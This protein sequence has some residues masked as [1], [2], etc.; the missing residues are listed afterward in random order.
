[1]YLNLVEDMSLEDVYA[2]KRRI[3]S[4]LR[5]DVPE[6]TAARVGIPRARD[7][8]ICYMDGVEKNPLQMR[9]HFPSP[10]EDWQYLILCTGKRASK[11]ISDAA[12]ATCELAFRGRRVWVVAPSYHLTRNVFSHVW[13]WVVEQRCFGPD[14]IE[15]AH[16]TRDRIDIKL[17]AGLGGS[18]IE[19]KSAESPIS[20][21]GVPVHLLILDEAAFVEE[22]I[23][24]D[25]LEPNTIDYRARTLFSTTPNGRN[26]IE[27]YSLRGLTK[28][29]RDA[30][31]GFYN[32]S[33]SSNPFIDPT[34]LESKRRQTPDLLW[35]QNYLGKFESLA[36]VVWPD[37]LAK[38]ISEGGHLIS[39]SGF[40]L[41]DRTHGIAIDIGIQHPT[42]AV[43]GAADTKGD[44]II[45]RDYLACESS[46]GEHADTIR[47]LNTYPLA[48][49]FISP[50]AVRTTP[51]E[52]GKKSR[53][54]AMKAFKRR[55]LPLRPANND[56]DF[57]LSV[58]SEYLRA[59]IFSES[60]DPKI[61]I[62]TE[63]VDLID[64]LGSY[65]WDTTRAGDPKNHP[66]KKDDDLSDA[67][68]YLMVARP[69]FQPP[70]VGPRYG[71]AGGIFVPRENVRRY[72]DI[73]IPGEVG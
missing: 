12:E 39:P 63:C 25:K 2:V 73:F 29:T 61:H 1:M 26:W 15:Y 60:A 59:S 69:S 7:G 22:H 56:V 47:S 3:L 72:G 33:T 57:G 49:G 55:G 52:R 28:D 36:G 38:D 54:N 14:S 21:M 17:K 43:W 45:Y 50:D 41:K 51:T 67:L 24:L 35:S 58:V 5:V 16:N 71:D 18:I 19:G 46:Y 20:L 66:R 8:S 30:G 4:R 9:V 32:C 23:W 10:E 11:S 53:D 34:W 37:F 68:R 65:I 48:Y 44:V 40:N 31:W 70:V 6:E 42:A 27:K 62:S 64:A 13:K